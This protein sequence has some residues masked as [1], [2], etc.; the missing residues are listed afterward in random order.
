MNATHPRWSRRWLLPMGLLAG[1][2]S[3]SFASV[4][5]I[6]HRSDGG[7]DFGGAVSRYLSFDPGK[8]TDAISQ[9]APVVV[10]LLGI[11]VTVVAIIVQLSSNRYSGVARMFVRDRV[12][13]AVL[14]YYVVA[15]INGVWLSVALHEGFV[16]TASL[17]LGIASASLGMLL[18]LPYFSYVFWFLEPVNLVERIRSDAE[19]SVA[20]VLQRPESAPDVLDA[21]QAATLASMAEL[22]D[23]AT[24]SVSG[25]DKIIASRAVDALMDFACGYLDQKSRLPGQ[26]FRIGR[27]LGENPDFTAMD[28]ESL[29]DLETRRTWVEWQVL[30]QYLSIYAEA[31]SSLREINYLIAIDTRYIGEKAAQRSDEELVA[32]VFRYMNSYLRATLNMRDVRTAYNVLNQYRLLAQAMLRHGRDEFAL[33]AVRHMGYYSHVSFDMT[34]NFVTE[35]VAYDVSSLC[36]AAHEFD[37]P[38]QDAMLALFMKLDR[39][40]RIKR[41]ER[42]LLGVRKAQVKLAAYY[43]SVGHEDRARLI[44]EDMREENAERVSIIRNELVSVAAKDFWEIIDRGRTFEYMP[45]AQRNALP[46]F[47]SMLDAVQQERSA[48]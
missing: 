3:L 19:R 16:P 6:D 28:P 12:N 5:L 46:A 27:S 36:Q 17:L 21:R 20:A 45:P 34:L 40:L 8:I 38:T 32:L 41:Q 37:S 44:A 39:P 9:I 31:G 1:L 23:I 47:F 48:V 25:K 24:H 4:Y 26:W 43:L 42:A 15:A 11:V 22:T 29:V 14:A 13:Q 10:A 2:A 30:R 7:Q 18:M 33:E 35:T